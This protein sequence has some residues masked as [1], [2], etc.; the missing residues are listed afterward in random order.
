MRVRWRRVTATLLAGATIGLGAP[1][2]A[3]W[4]AWSI[5]VMAASVRTRI[6]S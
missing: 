6:D 4:L 2:F 5:V 1:A 3:L